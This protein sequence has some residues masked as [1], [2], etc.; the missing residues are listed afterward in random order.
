MTNPAPNLNPYA[1][2]EAPTIAPP[3]LAWNPIGAWRDRDYLV[4]HRGAKLP[5]V[6][7]FSGQTEDLVAMRFE[8]VGPGDRYTLQLVLQRHYAS[9]L[10]PVTQELYNDCSRKLWGGWLGGIAGVC[11]G[12]VALASLNWPPWAL[13]WGV[14]AAGSLLGAV[15]CAATRY[16]LAL[17]DI[18]EHYVWL[19]GVSPVLLERLPPWPYPAQ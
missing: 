16:G 5:G 9:L 2:P 12:V 18:D 14:L 13:L 19:R 10:L 11:F 3:G 15:Y 7:V 8:W 4:M 6:C 17:Y 1:S